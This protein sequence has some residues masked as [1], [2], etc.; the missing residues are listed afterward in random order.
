M[1]KTAT[2]NVRV[3][4]EVKRE[5]E[6]VLSALGVPMSTAVDM[7]LRQVA[8]KRCIPFPLTLEESPDAG[9]D[10][11]SPVRVLSAEEVAESVRKA[12][13][14]FP[15]IARVYLFGSFARGDA[16]RDSDIDVRIELAGDASFSLI[17]V[18][19][20]AQAI[21]KD[22]GREVDVVSARAIKNESLAAAIERDGILVYER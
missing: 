11:A 3:R 6:S 5:A 8:L 21:E 2:L 9:E 19:R 13:K 14:K 7:F 10:A 15:E 1:E 16:T 22:T 4:P 12:A 17:D 20:F 18:S